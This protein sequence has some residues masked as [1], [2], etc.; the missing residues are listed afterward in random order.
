MRRGMR[1][2]EA[3]GLCH[4]ADVLPPDIP[5][6]ER[7]LDEILDFLETLS[8]EAERGKGFGLAYLSLDGLPVQ[9][10]PFVDDLIA[11]LHRRFGFMS[12]VGVAIGKFGARV[13]ASVSRPGVS[14]IIPKGEERGLDRKSV[15]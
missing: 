10:E 13:A 11:G 15:V 12:S 14:K 1:M 3:I 4:R 7:S 2:S 9:V 5:Y 8:P 6:Y